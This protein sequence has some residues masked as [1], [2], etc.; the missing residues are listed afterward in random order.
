MELNPGG[1]PDRPPLGIQQAIQSFGRPV[2]VLV[3]PDL[4]PPRLAGEESVDGHPWAVD[5]GY[6]EELQEVRVRTVRKLPATVRMR[7]V[8][9]LAEALTNFAA[10]AEMARMDRGE[11][12]GLPGPAIFREYASRADEASTEDTEVTV[13]A[14]IQPARV[15]R[16]DGYAALEVLHGD[17]VIVC[18]APT[19]VIPHVTLDLI[20][21]PPGR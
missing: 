17:D 3:H 7:P 5:L 13:G 15:L 21:P 20:S 6:G 19:G 12:P 2:G 16:V 9:L 8:H 11:R 4:G 14:T 18:L 10:N 1:R